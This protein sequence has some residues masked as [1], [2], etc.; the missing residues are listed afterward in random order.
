MQII[1]SLPTVTGVNIYKEKPLNRYTMRFNDQL[2]VLYPKEVNEIPSSGMTKKSLYF[3]PGQNFIPHWIL[4]EN[5][6][7]A[8]WAK[9]WMWGE[10]V[11]GY[12]S[13]AIL[14]HLGHS[15]LPSMWGLLMCQYFITK[16]GHTPHSESMVRT[17]CVWFQ[18]F[19]IYWDLFGGR[20]YRLSCGIVHVYFRRM[21]TMKTLPG[22][23]EL[24]WTIKRPVKCA[25]DR[26]VPPHEWGLFLFSEGK[27]I[28]KMTM[29][30]IIKKA[31]IRAEI[32]KNVAVKIID[33]FLS[34]VLI[35]RWKCEEY[36]LFPHRVFQHL[37]T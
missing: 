33:N 25:L 2:L 15:I 6:S 27:C 12:S 3:G 37:C 8:H 36:Y 32:L 10:M 24:I 20:I 21:L 16:E 30:Q 18:P 34:L 31:N 29:M 35:N 23:K 26:F 11:V 1:C 28:K 9:K 4:A 22:K 5:M 7:L 13:L 14:C 19:K 17:R